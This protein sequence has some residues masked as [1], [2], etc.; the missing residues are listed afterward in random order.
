MRRPDVPM[1]ARI[2]RDLRQAIASGDLP[3]GSRVPSEDALCRSYD[4]SRMTARQALSRL[5]DAGLLI[6]RQGIGTFV[7]QTKVARVAGRLLGFHEDAVAHGL[8]PST[9]VLQ[10]REE[11]AGPGDA[12]L[13]ECDPEATVLRVD[14]LRFHGDLPIGRNQVVVAPALVATF[15]DLDFAGSFYQGAERRLGIEIED[16]ETTVEAV[17]TEPDVAELLNVRP[18]DPLL[19]TTRVTRLTGGRLLGLTRTLYRGDRYYLSLTIRKDPPAM[20]G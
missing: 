19:R 5:A 14:R 16:A 8:D 9:Q 18:G 17:A 1:Y 7:A 15:A 10:R 4:V 20:L 11:P 12:A 13:L 2:E 6:R 3:L